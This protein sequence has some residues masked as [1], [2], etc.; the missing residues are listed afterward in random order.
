VSA[1]LDEHTIG[2]QYA[3]LAIT[4]FYDRSRCRHYAECVRGL[5][6]VFDVG[7]RP[8]IRPHLA[9]PE[10][11]SEVVRR[12]PTGALHYRL[13][14]GDAEQPTTPTTIRRDPA[15]PPGACRRDHRTTS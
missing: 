15:G 10:S 12:C 14:A 11:V 7:R 8:W 5:P 6:D 3:A 4:V 2:K 1:A 9:D 13:A